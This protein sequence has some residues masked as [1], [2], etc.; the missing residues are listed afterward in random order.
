MS[1]DLCIIYLASYDPTLEITET[2]I[3]SL[4]GQK[5]CVVLAHTQEDDTMYMR[6]YTLE[7]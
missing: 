6:Q 7:V 4:T 3:L 5:Q 1:R 2:H